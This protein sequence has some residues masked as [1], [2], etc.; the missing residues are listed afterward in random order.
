M[1]KVDGSII[2]NY[3]RDRATVYPLSYRARVIAPTSAPIDGWN[4]TAD[5]FAYRAH[6]YFAVMGPGYRFNATRLGFHELILQDEVSRPKQGR[7]LVLAYLC[8]LVI[9]LCV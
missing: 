9:D 7:W 6:N 8:N 3:R 2:I 5:G 4:L 1:D